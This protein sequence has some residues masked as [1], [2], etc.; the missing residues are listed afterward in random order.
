MYNKVFL[1]NLSLSDLAFVY[2][3]TATADKYPMSNKG[4]YHNGLIYTISGVEILRFRDRTIQTFPGTV[5]YIPKGESY[6]INLQGEK[7]VVIAIDFE[8]DSLPVRPFRIDFS[9]NNAIIFC[10]QDMEIKWERKK[11]YYMPECKSYFYKIVAMLSKQASQ[12]EENSKLQIIEKAEQYMRENYLNSDF[13]IEDLS[14]ITGTSLRYFETLF[15]SKYNTTPKAYIIS[16]KIERAKELLL[17]EK[18]LIKDVAIMLGYNDIYHFGKLF[19]A[20]TG[21]TPSEYRHAHGL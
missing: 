12:N 15:Q 9:E 5:L 16:L 18:L 21:F 6:T 10:F 1:N 19:K 8:S 2:T 7:S 13:R 14:K 20:R 3:Y 11:S 4:R 17:S